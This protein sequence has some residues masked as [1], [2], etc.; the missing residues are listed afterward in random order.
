MCFKITSILSFVCDD[1]GY[2]LFK[3]TSEV[4]TRQKKRDLGFI[5]QVRESNRSGRSA[6]GELKQSMKSHKKVCY[7]EQPSHR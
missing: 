3:P 5:K 4:S 2:Q 7:E 6:L 1:C